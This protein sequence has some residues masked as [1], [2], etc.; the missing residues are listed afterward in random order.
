MLLYTA[1]L[2]LNHKE[3]SEEQKEKIVDDV[4]SALSLTKCQNVVIGNQLNRGIS[5]G[6]F[7]S[8]LVQ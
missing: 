3:Y 1:E 5:G 6:K 7:V 2:K 8:K 4:I